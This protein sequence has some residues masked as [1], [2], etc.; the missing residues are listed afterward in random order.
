M[1]EAT[2]RAHN[3]AGAFSHGFDGDIRKA[4]A[5]IGDEMHALIG[6]RDIE[7]IRGT[8]NQCLGQRV[9]LLTIELCRMRRMWAAK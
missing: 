5:Q 8:A 4:L 9:A 6:H 3:D 1:I 2:D 7:P